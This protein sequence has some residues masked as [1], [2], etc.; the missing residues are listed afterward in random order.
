MKIALITGGS[1]GIGLAVAQKLQKSGYTPVINYF[2]DD[3]TAE[4]VK[5]EYG[6][7]TIKCDVSKMED[8]RNMVSSVV[9]KYG[10][11]DVLVNSAGVAIKQKLLIDVN[12]EELLRCVNINL[13]GTIFTCQAVLPYMIEKRSGAI[14]NI[15]SVYGDEGGSCEAVYSASKGGINAFTKALSKEVGSA[16]IRVNAVAPGFIDTA[17]NAHLS[18]EDVDDFCAELSLNRVGTPEEV[19]DAVYF[20]IN[21]TYVTGVILPVDGGK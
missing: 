17:M 18:K 3:L 12:S 7:D 20:L 5:K 6:F 13:L 21:N 16:N 14:V 19:A 11:I 2:H 10:K 8:V 1:K 9:K 4:K 15:S